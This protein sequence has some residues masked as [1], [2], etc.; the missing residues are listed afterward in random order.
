[1]SR[2]ARAWNL[3]EVVT[4]EPSDA[5]EAS[6]LERRRSRC[7]GGAGVL[8]RSRWGLPVEGARDDADVEEVEP[9]TRGGSG[10]RL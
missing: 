3:L 6:R 9:G 8:K 5:E 2:E 4:P 7:V 1:V 10:G